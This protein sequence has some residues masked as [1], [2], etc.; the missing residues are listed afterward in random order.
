MNFW[1]LNIGNPQ[2]LFSMT[3]WFWSPK[4]SNLCDNK[5]QASS[6]SS[7]PSSTNSDRG[8]NAAHLS[9]HT[10][11]CFNNRSCDY[12]QKCL[13]SPPSPCNACSLCKD[14]AIKLADVQC[15]ILLSIIK[16][17]MT[18]I[19][20]EKLLILLVI[21]PKNRHLQALWFPSWLLSPLLWFVPY[22]T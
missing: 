17:P 3:F 4:K 7:T 14:C 10:S 15:R 18:L 16:L 2:G 6:W 22:W 9:N 21:V 11:H 1:Q 8:S 20:C 19:Q 13:G 12:G 5:G